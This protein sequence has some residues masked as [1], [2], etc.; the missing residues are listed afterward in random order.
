MI[1][2]MIED[3]YLTI[4]LLSMILSSIGLLVLWERDPI[5]PKYL[6]IHLIIL[7]WSGLMSLTGILDHSLS[8][9]FLLFQPIAGHLYFDW[10]VT[11]PLMLLAVGLTAYHRSELEWTWILSLMS[12]QSTIILLGLLG[13]VSEWTIV[14][15]GLSCLLYVPLF[16]ILWIPIR[17]IGRQTGFF[18]LSI[19]LSFITL[20][21]ISYPILW[22]TSP[23]L[24]G[25]IDESSFILGIT[26]VSMISKIGLAIIDLTL[27]RRSDRSIIVGQFPR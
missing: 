9:V 27:I 5:D 11:T 16:W 6:I 26:I 17:R 3:P 7:S 12:I 15:V 13:E 2:A 22:I 10:I 1:D 18:D 25:W 24:L 14:F 4:Y 23:I 20:S 8:S 21:W 19:I